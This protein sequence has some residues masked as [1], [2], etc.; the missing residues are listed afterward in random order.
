MTV[1]DQSVPEPSPPPPRGS[2]LFPVILAMC[3]ALTGGYELGQL[4][5][6]HGPAVPGAAGAHTHG[7]GVTAG[8]EVGGLAISAGGYTLVP[9]STT[10]VPG[11]PGNLRFR[12][13]GPDGAAVTRYATVADRQ[14]HLVVV[15]RDLSGYQHLHPALGG[16]GNWSTP[17]LLSAAGPWR[18]FADF[19]AIAANGTQVPL[20][21]GADL[22][23]AGSY[24]PRALPAAQ[25]TWIQDGLGVAYSGTPRVGTT[26]PLVFQVSRTGQP[27]SLERHL[28]AYG[29]LV[30]V[31]EGD[32]GY[33]H[34][35]PDPGLVGGG[36]RFW[37]TAPSVGRYRLFFDYQTAGTVHTAE[38]TLEV[39]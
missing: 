8:L 10:F 30:V 27:A 29:H 3:L 21:L 7:P 12:I 5:H 19:S 25:R 33:L 35:H 2:R 22:T 28:G 23:V 9:A 36:V 32:L 1:E 16:D 14:L 4:T 37:V 34:V 26:Q 18:F 39:Q 17:L 38:F 20:T 11:V 13:T 6:S 31:R 15:R 24:E